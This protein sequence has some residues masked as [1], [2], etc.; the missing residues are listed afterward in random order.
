VKFVLNT[1]ESHESMFNKWSAKSSLTF[2]MEPKNH[3]IF[4]V[5][6]FIFLLPQCIEGF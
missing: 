1:E 6:I 2:R 3:L 4:P 5:F